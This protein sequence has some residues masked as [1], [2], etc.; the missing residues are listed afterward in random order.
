MIDSEVGRADHPFVTTSEKS[1]Q[2]FGGRIQY[3][4]GPIRLQA[5]SRANYNSN[6]SS[7][8]THSAKSRTSGLDASYAAKRWLGVDAGYSKLHLD[9]LT[10]LAYFAG[11]LVDND[12][13]LYVSNVHSAYVS[14][15][16]TLKQRVDLTLGY[17]R[18][19]DAG[20]GRA[21]P[22]SGPAGG[23]RLATFRSAQT[24]PLAFQ[25]P[26][27]RLSVRLHDKIRW[28]LGYQYYGYREDFRAS[29][30]YRAHT[31]FTSLIWSF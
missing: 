30:G 10:G 20:D 3:K 15:R 31:G 27:A 12:A 23:S 9:T 11:D 25:S 16:A 17:T 14:A 13:S 6:S 8:F 28:N 26:Q 22:T 4:S 2:A 1:Y 19:Q 29:Q 5:Y 18:V 24:F 21:T 7:L